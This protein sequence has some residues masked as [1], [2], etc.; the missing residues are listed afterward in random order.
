MSRNEWCLTEE[1]FAKLLA[2][3]SQDPDEAAR[4]YEAL[5]TRLIRYFEWRRVS[6]A[7]DRTDETFNRIA[8][9]IEEGQQIDNVAAY[10]FR[11]AYLISL[12][13]MKEPQYDELDPEKVPP[14]DE[15]FVDEGQERRQKCFDLC[16]GRLST[17]RRQVLLDFYEE[18]LRAKIENRKKLADQLK[19]TV[20][21]LRIRVHRIRK[22]LEQCIADCLRQP[23]P[24]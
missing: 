2:A 20:N 22:S 9:R 7:E 14:D 18:E 8:K 13:A 15:Q 19:I 3:F 16:L 12:E 10:A 24:T 17:E 6:L 23:E 11:V 1:A 4:Q 21:A 5:R